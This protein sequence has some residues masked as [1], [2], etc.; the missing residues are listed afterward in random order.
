VKYILTHCKDKA[1]LRLLLSPLLGPPKPKPFAPRTNPVLVFIGDKSL[2]STLDSSDY[3]MMDEIMVDVMDEHTVGLYQK[4]EEDY[5]YEDDYL[6]SSDG[7]Q[8]GGSS[9]KKN[10]KNK[11]KQHDDAVDDEDSM[12]T[13]GELIFER[14]F[15]LEHS[16]LLAV[17]EFSDPIVKSLRSFILQDV[18]GFEEK[19]MFLSKETFKVSPFLVC[20]IIIYQNNNNNNVVVVDDVCI[21]NLYTPSLY[22]SLL[23]LISYFKE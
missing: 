20:E 11:N 9:M 8:V 15:R 4:E 7:I 3:E 6:D 12:K 14:E 2:H 1:L 16:W 23:L 18:F 17:Q 10:K 21:F 19:T 13:A 22:I 5:Y